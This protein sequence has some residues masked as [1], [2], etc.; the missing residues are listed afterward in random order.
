ML[1]KGLFKGSFYF[2]SGL[3]GGGFPH[4]YRGVFRYIPYV[5]KSTRHKKIETWEAFCNK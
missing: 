5:G 3:M 2:F 1:G 4:F